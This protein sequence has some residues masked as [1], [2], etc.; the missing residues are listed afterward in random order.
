MNLLQKFFQIFTICGMASLI[1]PVHAGIYTTDVSISGSIAG[2]PYD[3]QRDSTSSISGM[4]VGGGSPDASSIS[5]FAQAKEPSSLAPISLETYSIFVLQNQAVG[6]TGPWSSAFE[7]VNSNS[8][9]NQQF[10]IG[11]YSESIGSVINGFITVDLNLMFVNQTLSYTADGMLEQSPGPVP[12]V[13]SGGFLGPDL[14]IGPGVTIAANGSLVTSLK[15][16]STSEKTRKVEILNVA[17]LI[18]STPLFDGSAYYASSLLEIPFSALVGETMDLNVDLGLYVFATWNEG[19]TYSDAFLFD[20]WDPISISFSTPGA[21][22][23]SADGSDAYF[24]PDKFV[25]ST[26][27]EPNNL[28]LICFGILCAM[29]IRRFGSHR[30]A[31]VL[32]VA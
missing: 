29:L 28:S 6:G 19:F 8:Q 4:N 14:S 24:G 16:L 23:M 21:Y 17:D 32:Q 7:T 31:Q 27:D 3:E 11:S 15:N 18:S 30:P 26:V 9:L 5:A 12:V 25:A 20:V 10:T 2:V 22:Y 1:V 13:N